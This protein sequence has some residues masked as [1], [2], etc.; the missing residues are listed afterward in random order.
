MRRRLTVMALLTL[1]ALSPGGSRA[2]D[3]PRF[4]L[5]GACYCRRATQLDCLGQFPRVECERKC[6]EALCDDWF[7][8]ERRPCWNWGYGG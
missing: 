5:D 1:A 3:D 6:T 4:V 8:L 2:A 7:W